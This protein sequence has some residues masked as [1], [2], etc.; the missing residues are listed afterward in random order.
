[1]QINKLIQAS[2]SVTALSCFAAAQHDTMRQLRLMRIR[3]DKSAVCAIDRHLQ[4]EH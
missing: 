4:A 3:V 2:I 1:M